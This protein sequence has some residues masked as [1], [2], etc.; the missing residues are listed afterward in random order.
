MKKYLQ[1]AMAAA[2]VATGMTAC[3]N[4][5]EDGDGNYVADFTSVAGL[6]TIPGLSFLSDR[7]LGIYQYSMSDASGYTDAYIYT[8]GA[9]GALDS[10]EPQDEAGTTGT[11]SVSQ[12]AD[13]YYGGF[14]PTTFAASSEEDYCTPACGEYHSGNGALIC[15]PG[16]VCRAIF[17]RHIGLDLSTLLGALSVGKKVQGLWVAPTT[18][19]AYVDGER[20]EAAK[21]KYDLSDLAIESLPAGYKI[22]FVV[23]GYVESFKL[24]NFKEAMNSI[25]DAGTS[26]AKGGKLAAAVTLASSDANGKVTVNT[27]WQYV[28]LSGTK[29]YLWEATL[30]VVNGSGQTVDSWLNDENYTNYCLVDDI[31]YES[32]SLF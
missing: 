5:D 29:A 9:Y 28:D 3:H 6:S 10:E 4:D 15:N 7:T 18:E 31:T 17:S 24:S 32:A 21:Q 12:L 23:Y 1:M 25:K 19:M 14:C 13:M 30:R 22:E 8:Q 26:M 27:D 11:V 2:V 16:T 20:F